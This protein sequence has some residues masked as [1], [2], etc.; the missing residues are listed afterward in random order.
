MGLC[1]RKR[2]LCITK[3]LFAVITKRSLNKHSLTRFA[4]LDYRPVRNIEKE[5]YLQWNLLRVVSPQACA[6]YAI[7]KALLRY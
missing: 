7:S 6:V 3:M 4:N 2:L 1:T 5:I